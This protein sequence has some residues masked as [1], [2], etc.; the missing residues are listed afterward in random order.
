[1]THMKISWIDLRPYGYV[2]QEL[3][4]GYIYCPYMPLTHETE[5]DLQKCISD[6]EKAYENKI[7]GN[8]E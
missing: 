2:A 6:L 1:M 4:G 8:L 7:R 5:E 3:S